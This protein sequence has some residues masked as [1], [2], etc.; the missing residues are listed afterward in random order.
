MMPDDVAGDE[1][2]APPLTLLQRAWVNGWRWLEDHL[3]DMTAV[4]DND[5]DEE[6]PRAS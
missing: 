3:P 4:F 6:D 2:S 1:I 5:T